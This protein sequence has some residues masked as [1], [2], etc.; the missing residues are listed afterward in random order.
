MYDPKTICGNTSKL[1]VFDKECM[2]WNPK[3]PIVDIA[4]ID[5]SNEQFKKNVNHVFAV[6]DS[7]DLYD[8]KY[9]FMEESFFAEDIEVGDI[10]IVEE[11]ADRVGKENIMVK[12]HPRNPVNRFEKL[13]YKTNKNVSIPWEVI[14]LN[15]NM[16][17]KV[18]YTITSSAVLS[19]ARLFGI[20]PEVH[21]L[22]DKLESIPKILNAGLLDITKKFLKRFYP[23]NN[24]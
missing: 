3:I 19:P 14:I 1:Y 24:N 10:S 2:D 4:K 22:Y 20:K 9:L 18:L 11:I 17:D 23:N 12:I 21:L 7:E 6:D 16:N 15:Q 5:N 13:G 8:T